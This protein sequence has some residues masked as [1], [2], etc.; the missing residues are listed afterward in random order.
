MNTIE[1]KKAFHNLIDSIDNERLLFNFY[2]LIKNRITTSK[3]FCNNPN[4]I[5]NG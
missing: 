2:D 4:E 5:I 3:Q 1:L